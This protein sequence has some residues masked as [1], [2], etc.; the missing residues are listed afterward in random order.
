MFLTATLPVSLKMTLSP[1]LTV[2]GRELL[3][4]PPDLSPLHDENTMPPK[5][6]EK[7][8]I[9]GK[10]L[11]MAGMLGLFILRNHLYSD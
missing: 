4:S 5:M 6:R 10:Y 7:T 3:F 1:E 8:T 11:F 2:S 9:N